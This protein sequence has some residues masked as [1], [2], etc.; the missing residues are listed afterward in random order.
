MFEFKD[1]D[2]LS[3]GKIDLIIDKKVF[4]DDIKGYVP[5]YKYKITLHESSYKIGTISIRIGNNENTELGGHIGYGINEEFRGNS[6][7]SKACKIIMQVALAHGLNRL[8]ITCN[9]NNYASRKTCENIGANL[10]KTIDLP[11]DSDLYKK[12]EMQSCKYEWIKSSVYI[13][14]C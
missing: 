12:G 2:Y 7:A 8:V 1:F 13:N 3:D 5:T 14:L 6:F 11:I 4:G 9:P 10:N